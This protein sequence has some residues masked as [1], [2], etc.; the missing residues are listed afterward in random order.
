MP[1]SQTLPYRNKDVALKARPHTR[2][3]STNR[4]KIRNLR[5]H[6]STRVVF[7][8]DHTSWECLA[9]KIRATRVA[10]SHDNV[11]SADWLNCDRNNEEWTNSFGSSAINSC[12]MLVV[13]KLSQHLLEQKFLLYGG[14]KDNGESRP[15]KQN[16]CNDTFF[17]E[18]R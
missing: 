8:R 5:V 11:L 18:S 1:I 16:D 12:G 6:E 17:E 2:I 15:T 3:I 13:Q 7:S 4:A 14:H 10:W 9:Q